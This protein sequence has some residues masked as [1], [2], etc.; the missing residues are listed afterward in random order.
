[1]KTRTKAQSHHQENATLVHRS[2]FRFSTPP[3]AIKLTNRSGKLPPVHHWFRLRIDR[4]ENRVRTVPPPP[5]LLHTGGGRRR[6]RR[7]YSDG[8]LTHGLN[9]YRDGIG[10]SYSHVEWLWQLILY[11][12]TLF[13]SV[14]V[15]RRAC[16]WTE[17]SRWSSQFFGRVSTPFISAICGCSF[18]WLTCQENLW[19][20]AVVNSCGTPVLLLLTICDLL[21]VS[22][23]MLSSFF[24][25][26]RLANSL[27]IFLLN[28]IYI[29]ICQCNII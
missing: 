1:M 28:Y 21:E 27:I 19:L 23:S 26:P 15:A 8:Y 16:T 5:L 6:R 17:A 3:A 12:S 7:V 25:F 20:L 13:Q 11:S 14:V 2:E 29:Y 9:E 18:V 4:P 10:L 22:G 24:L